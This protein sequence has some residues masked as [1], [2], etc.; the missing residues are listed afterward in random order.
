M[1]DDATIKVLMVCLGNICRSPTA[2]ATFRKQVENA[3]LADL[4]LIDSAGTSN[5]HE[6]ELPD[7]RSM[8]HAALRHYDLG[9][10]RSRPIIAE[11]FARFDY[12]L[13]MDYQ[14]LRD[15]QLRCPP[16]YRD[17]LALFLGEGVRGYVEV[18]DP[19]EGGEAG[20]ELVLDLCEERSATLLTQL[21]GRHLAGRAHG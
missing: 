20:F 16:Q 9:T 10:Q 3:G 5:W 18:P 7:T 1:S 4:F 2:E 8:R 12:I 17:K 19:Y 21:S 13:A 6:G 15:L 11:D 14:N